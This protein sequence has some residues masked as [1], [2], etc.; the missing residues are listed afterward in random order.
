MNRIGWIAFVFV[1]YLGEA[2]PSPTEPTKRPVVC[3]GLMKNWGN[4][5]DGPRMIKDINSRELKIDWDDSIDW[6]QTA[7][8][9]ILNSGK[10][11]AVFRSVSWLGTMRMESLVIAPNGI[12]EGIVGDT[13][14]GFLAYS[15]GRVPKRRKR[16]DAP[17]DPAKLPGDLILF[18][19]TKTRYKSAQ[20]ELHII[21]YHERNLIVVLPL[22][23]DARG[24]TEPIA[25][26][27][28][29]MA[30]ETF[31]EACSYQRSK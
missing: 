18:D 20:T 22:L 21:R 3:N 29:P 2:Y 31:R 23:R 13:L 15:H 14:S 5:A 24:S 26:V 10:K 16:T 30:N 19:G 27:V 25:I 17:F 6:W 12:P 9:D 28:E 1:L 7:D 4:D 8:I 11:Q